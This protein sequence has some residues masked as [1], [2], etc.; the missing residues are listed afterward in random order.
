[1]KRKRLNI[2][3]RIEKKVK[4]DKIFLC[5]EMIMGYAKGGKTD[6]TFPSED[7]LMRCV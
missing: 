2:L 6:E 4:T 1:M 7:M 5:E 3:V